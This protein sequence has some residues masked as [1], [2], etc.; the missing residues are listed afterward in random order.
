M[1]W[2]H[3]F[4]PCRSGVAINLETA[5]LEARESS[6]K[7]SWALVCPEC[8]RLQSAV[9]L[10][11]TRGKYNADGT[12]LCPVDSCREPVFNGVECEAHAALRSARRIEAKK[13]RLSTHEGT[14]R[15]RIWDIVS[16]DDMK[17]FFGALQRLPTPPWS[18][19]KMWSRIADAVADEPP[20]PDVFLID[21]ETVIVSHTPKPLE[22]SIL[23]A[24]GEHLY[25]TTVDYGV[26]VA[27][28]CQG[29]GQQLLG[30]AIGIY[31]REG[32]RSA[33]G[34]HPTHGQTPAAIKSRLHEIGLGLGSGSVLVEWSEN[35]WD[36]RAIRSLCGEAS[37]PGEYLRGE[38]LLRLCGYRGPMDLETLYYLC[39]PDCP[40]HRRHHRAEWDVRKLHRVLCYILA[41]SRA[42]DGVPDQAKL[43]PGLAFS[44]SSPQGTGS[45]Q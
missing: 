5:T 2:R 15:R 40:L 37:V 12:R 33:H 25:T 4:I 11:V 14:N 27:E 26:D 18:R 38:D 29:I 44:A 31:R 36:W 41:P 22:L 30:Y 19:D 43:D 32:A 23:R 7:V 9:H 13:A 20:V 3:G 45:A 10:W 21:T 8:R 42:H 39:F 24:N 35:G 6:G 28:L 34:R 17:S 16:P 1:G